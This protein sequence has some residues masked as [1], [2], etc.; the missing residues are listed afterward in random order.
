[1]KSG[2][3]CRLFG[4]LM[5]CASAMPCMA[6][7]SSN[8]TGMTMESRM[9]AGGGPAVTGTYAMVNIVCGPASPTGMSGTNGEAGPFP[10]D[11]YALLFPSSSISRWIEF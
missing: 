8:G 3:H 5:F 10:P 9:S 6:G 7:V 4:F 2:F 1:M 11:F